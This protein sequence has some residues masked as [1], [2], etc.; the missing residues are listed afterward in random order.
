MATVL[1]FR[2]RTSPAPGSVRPYTGRLNGRRGQGALPRGRTSLLRDFN[3]A[4]A[5]AGLTTFLWYAVGMLP[6]QIAV[7][8]SFGLAR[9][10]AS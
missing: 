6:V 1:P 9:T 2:P 5:W 10:Q 4:A 8:A 3:Q 7:I